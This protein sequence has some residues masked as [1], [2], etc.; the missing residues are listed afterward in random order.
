MFRREFKQDAVELVTKRGVSAPQNLLPIKLSKLKQ[1]IEDSLADSAKGRVEVWNTRYHKAHGQE[2]EAWIT[3]DGQRAHS[4]G[5]VTHLVAWYERRRDMQ[6]VR[7]CLD[8]RDRAQMDGYREA[9]REANKQLQA[10]GVIPHWAF[11]NAVFEY[12][13]MSLEQ[14]LRSG[15]MIVCASGMFNKRLGKRRLQ[16]MNVSREHELIQGFYHV[17]CAFEGLRIRPAP[18]PES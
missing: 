16:S 11:N 1:R 2:G 13:H 17:R 14:V 6:N 5:S 10:E 7:G 3:I 9:K 15:Q 12:L 4:M 18:K 8:Y